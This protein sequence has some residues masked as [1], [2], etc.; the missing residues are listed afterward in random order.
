MRST[1]SAL[2]VASLVALSL[3][4]CAGGATGGEAGNQEEAGVDGSYVDVTDQQGSI[5]EFVGASDDAEVVRCEGVDGGW[6][7][8][9]TVTNPT[10]AA[11]SYRLYVAFNENQD[12]QGLVQVD[13]VD[14]AAGATE[15]W[16]VEAPLTSDD[17]SCLLRVERFD[18]QG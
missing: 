17:L 15:Q 3:T 8:E 18:P 1:H 5:E 10:D 9:G 4:S 11:Q 12:T 7:S 2:L 13:I 16:S 14:V 6:V